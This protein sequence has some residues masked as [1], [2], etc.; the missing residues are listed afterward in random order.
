MVSGERSMQF[1]EHKYGVGCDV[2]GEV[3]VRE[4]RSIVQLWVGGVFEKCG[5]Y[6]AVH[7]T[8]LDSVTEI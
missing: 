1:H 7:V 3:K 4:G 2:G 8:H 6:L 5:Y